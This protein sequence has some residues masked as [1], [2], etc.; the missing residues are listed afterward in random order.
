MAKTRAKVL[1]RRE[2]DDTD[3]K[4]WPKNMPFKFERVKG[5]VSEYM[6]DRFH[7][8]PDVN[9]VSLFRG[10]YLILG[11]SY[12]HND[13]SA[14]MLFVLNPDGTP[15]KSRFALRNVQIFYTLQDAKDEILARIGRKLEE[16]LKKAEANTEKT[17]IKESVAPTK[18]VF[19]KPKPRCY[20]SNETID[21]YCSTLSGDKEKEPIAYWIYDEKRFIDFDV[22]KLSEPK[23]A[24][25]LFEFRDSGWSIR[26]TFKRCME[27]V[28]TNERR[29][30]R[31]NELA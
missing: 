13:H 5:I 26:G 2:P 28:E 24:D 19:E 31:E 18:K 3:T 21:Y 25:T 10:Y 23:G 8:C 22:I 14:N 29:R 11:R 7:R 20:W 15:M 6:S 30:F 12:D 17:Q 4:P 16:E 9:K 1:W 27:L